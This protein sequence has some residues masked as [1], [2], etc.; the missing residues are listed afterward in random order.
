VGSKSV[1]MVVVVLEDV[2]VDGAE[3]PGTVSG[4]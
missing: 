1:S 2:V 3:P 4:G